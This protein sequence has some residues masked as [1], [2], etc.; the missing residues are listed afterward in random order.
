MFE[1]TP[2]ATPPSNPAADNSPSAPV[3]LSA[4][5]QQDQAAVA[6]FER[7]KL[8]RI[9]KIILLV[10]TLFIVAIVVG[11]GIWLN[12]FLPELLS[13]TTT[14]NTNT[15]TLIRPASSTVNLA[16]KDTDG[17]GLPDGWE[18]AHGKDPL[19]SIDQIDF[20]GLQIVDY[21]SGRDITANA[22]GA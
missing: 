7:A 9:Q 17:D 5:A 13:A 2:I 10:A 8:S 14:N 20:E 22:Q 1:N 3:G 11:V 4:L 12:S 19:D 15:N 21:T 6:L 18:V 16:S